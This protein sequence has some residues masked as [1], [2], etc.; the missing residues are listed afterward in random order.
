M[1]ASKFS[2]ANSNTIPVPDNDKLIYALSCIRRSREFDPTEPAIGNAAEK[3]HL[4]LLDGIA[5]L[6]VVGATADV[7]AVSFC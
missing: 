4:K 2:L 6:L 3:K 5:L 1:P 7:A